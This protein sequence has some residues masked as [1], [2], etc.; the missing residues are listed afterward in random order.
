MPS[1]SLRTERYFQ[2]RACQFDALYAE[3]RKSTYF[4]NRL[5]RRPLY[6]RVRCA[7]EAFQGLRD[8]TVLDVGCGS[9]RNSV[10]FAKSGARRVVGI[11]FSA[12][13]IDLARNCAR[14]H[15]VEAQCEFILGDVLTHP[16]TERFNVVVALGVFDYVREP[17]QLL[18][19]MN[20]LANSKVAASFPGWSLLRAPLRKARYWWR[21]CPVYFFTRRQ[22]L[23]I[24]TDAG[25]EAQDLVPLSGRAG[26]VLVGR[27]K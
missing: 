16:F 26:W 9:G 24:S 20:E 17:H 13:M 18:R 11:D 21:N 3:E 12:N 19:R 15:G 7:V 23:Q 2:E 8:F 5:F 1:D 4:L 10:V 14:Q 6:E 25:L 22:L 27:A